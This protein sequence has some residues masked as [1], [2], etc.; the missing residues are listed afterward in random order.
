MGLG[1]IWS[2]LYHDAGHLKGFFVP[3]LLI[4]DEA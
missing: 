1:E 4:K 2:L 3:T